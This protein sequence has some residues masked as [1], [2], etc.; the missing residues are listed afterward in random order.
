MR[1]HI[2][3][4]HQYR[5]INLLSIGYVFPEQISFTLETLDIRP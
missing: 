4:I 2:S 1:P 3:D 5:N